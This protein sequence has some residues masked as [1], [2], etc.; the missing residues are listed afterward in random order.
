RR[1]L[2]GPHDPGPRERRCRRLPGVLRRLANQPCLLRRRRLRRHDHGDL[3]GHLRWLCLL[4]HAV[5]QG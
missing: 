4:W 5:R 2:H 1:P 3:C